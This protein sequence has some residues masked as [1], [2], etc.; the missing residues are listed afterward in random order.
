MKTQPPAGE[1]TGPGFRSRMA[2]AGYSSGGTAGLRGSLPGS[3]APDLQD[4]DHSI[5][6]QTSS[7]RKLEKSPW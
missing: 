1:Q 3:P 5:F 7:S 2:R 6:V 4:D